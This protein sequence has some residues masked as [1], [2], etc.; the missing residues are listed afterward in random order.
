MR[1]YQARFREGLEVKS[2]GLLGDKSPLCQ[3]GTYQETLQNIW[4]VIPA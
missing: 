1:E 2:S 3:L 4:D